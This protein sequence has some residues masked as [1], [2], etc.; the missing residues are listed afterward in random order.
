M[1]N[2]KKGPASLHISFNGSSDALLNQRHSQSKGNKPA[3]C[4]CTLA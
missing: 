4:I 1:I 3:P 2:L